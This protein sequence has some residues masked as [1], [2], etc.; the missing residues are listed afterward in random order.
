MYRY[1]HISDRAQP[2]V[3]LYSVIVRNGIFIIQAQPV[4]NEIVQ[5]PYLESVLYSLPACL[6]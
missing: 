3:F 1:V 4:Y 6:L 2:P 5:V